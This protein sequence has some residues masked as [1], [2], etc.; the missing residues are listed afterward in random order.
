MIVQRAPLLGYVLFLLLQVGDQKG[1]QIARI[2]ED[3]RRL[4]T[5]QSKKRVNGLCITSN[6]RR[7]NLPFVQI[8]HAQHHIFDVDG[9]DPLVARLVAAR[10]QYVMQIY[11]L[12]V[13]SLPSGLRLNI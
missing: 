3:C 12:D 11:P 10:I 7:S 1:D 2:I 8:V 13:V 5:S 4:E 6:R 9:N